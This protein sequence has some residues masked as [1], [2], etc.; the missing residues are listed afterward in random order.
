M[1]AISNWGLQEKLFCQMSKILLIIHSEFTHI[2]RDTG[3]FV[4]AVT[5]PF[6]LIISFSFILSTDVRSIKV[7]AVV[8]SPSPATESFLAPLKHNPVFVFKGQISSVEEGERMMRTNAINAML[9]LHRDFDTIMP[10]YS[11]D[12]TLPMPVQIIT[13]ASNCVTASAASLYLQ[14]ALEIGPEKQDFASVRMLYNPRLQSAYFFCPGLIALAIVLMCVIYS[15]MAMAEEKEKGT[16]ENLILSPISTV[17]YL[18]GKLFPYLCLGMFAGCTGLLSSYFLVGVPI[19]GSIALILAITLLYVITSLI[20][21]LIVSNFCHSRVDAYVLST[22]VIM[23]PVMYFGGVEVPVDNLPS[24]AQK[25]SG[26]IYVRWYAD[27]M[28]KIMIGGVSAA[29]VLKETIM[30]SLSTIVFLAGS[31]YLLRKDR[32]LLG[33]R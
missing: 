11:L 16:I 12:P 22:A 14:S 3:L 7:A 25:V 20:L 5:I 32:W 29:H 19:N 31:L 4:L 10:Q 15:S 17:E 9:V 13:D 28:R 8:Q 1:T 2:I 30:I 27:A 24:W 18:T 26:L 21:G 6:F 33:N 23:L